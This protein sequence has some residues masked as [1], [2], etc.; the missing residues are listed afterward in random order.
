MPSIWLRDPSLIDL[1]T[2][3]YVLNGGGEL[4]F[5]IPKLRGTPPAAVLGVQPELRRLVTAWKASG[6][7]GE[8]LLS[9]DRV[10]AARLERTSARLVPTQGANFRLAWPTLEPIRRAQL[11]TER[12]QW[13][14]FAFIH[15]ANLLLNPRC[16]MLGGPCGRCGLYYVKNTTRQKTFCGR[17][18]GQKSGATAATRKRRDSESLDKLDRVRKLADRWTESRSTLDWK[19]WISR[20]DPRISLTFLTRAVNSGKLRAPRK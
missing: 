8:K 19:R 16:E 6:P 5:G 18:C 15:F 7:N 9:S 10:L 1:K 2:I 20:R 11:P 3:C 4:P 14:D 17:R 12:E 13:E